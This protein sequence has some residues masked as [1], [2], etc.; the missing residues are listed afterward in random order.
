PAAQAERLDTH[1]KEAQATLLKRTDSSGRLKE[2]REVL[3]KVMKWYTEIYVVKSG[4]YVDLGVSSFIS[5]NL[6]LRFGACAYHLREFK[7]Y[8]GL[9]SHPKNEEKVRV[10]FVS[11]SA[12]QIAT[13]R[14][15]ILALNSSPS[16]TCIVDYSLLS[17]CHPRGLPTMKVF[18][19]SL[20]AVI[21]TA[22]SLS[23]TTINAIPIT[24]TTTPVP[25][26]QNQVASHSLANESFLPQNVQ[27]PTLSGCD[28]SVK[29]LIT[30]CIRFRRNSP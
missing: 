26:N 27:L 5:R 2:L 1:I 11:L 4:T 12:G 16:S 9:D 30:A 13:S 7:V 15:S 8:L 3:D 23:F 18:T 6:T 10:L 24:T 22:C 17:P 20:S 19:I 25:H 29:K 21:V 14:I 28:G